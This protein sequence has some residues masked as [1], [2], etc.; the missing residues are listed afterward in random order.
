[1]PFLVLS[2]AGARRAGFAQAAEHVAAATLVLSTIYIAFNETLA[3]WQ[4]VWFA[5]S[6]LALAISLVR[7][8]DAPG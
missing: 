5:A 6:L 7:A 4:A 2:L 1:M 8:R 3:N